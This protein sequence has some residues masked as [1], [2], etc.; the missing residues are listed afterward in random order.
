MKWVKDWT[1]AKVLELEWNKQ[2]SRGTKC[3]ELGMSKNSFRVGLV[4]GNH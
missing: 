2:C 3:I 1:E 4:E